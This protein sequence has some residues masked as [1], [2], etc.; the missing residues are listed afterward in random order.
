[1]NGM[2][3]RVYILNFQMQITKKKEI[4]KNQSGV[5]GNL[6]VSTVPS[7]DQVR[8]HT[9]Q[10]LRLAVKA[11]S[12]D[13]R[14]SLNITTRCTSSDESGVV[15]LSVKYRYAYLYSLHIFLSCA[16]I[17]SSRL[18]IFRVEIRVFHVPNKTFPL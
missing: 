10:W 1:M 9:A 14:V 8:F 11:D 6:P 12:V 5:L 15:S 4:K 16:V 13:S 3:Q 2:R 7:V 17:I 18:V